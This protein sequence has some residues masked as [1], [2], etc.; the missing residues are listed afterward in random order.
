MNTVYMIES[1]LY[2]RVCTDWTKKCRGIV[3]VGFVIFFT[4][5]AT[6]TSALP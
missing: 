1:A 3:I 5:L 6:S 4:F 2:K